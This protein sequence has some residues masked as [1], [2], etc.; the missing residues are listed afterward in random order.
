MLSLPIVFVSHASAAAVIVDAFVDTILR[1]GCGLEP[2]QIFYSSGED[3]GVP[4][5]KD[6]IHHVREQ[7]GEPILVVAIISPTYQTRPVCVAEL[8]AAWG[9]SGDLFPLAVPGMARTDMEGVLEGMTVRYLNDGAALDELR[10]RINKLTGNTSSTATW[11]RYKEQWR[12]DVDELAAKVASPRAVTPEELE[13]AQRDLTGVR[14]ALDQAETENKDLRSRI[15]RYQ[16]ATLQKGAQRR[17]CLRVR[18]TGLTY[19]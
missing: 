10:D 2:D 16:E 11:G 3:T 8:G 12:R 9:R 1:L 5:G 17:S 4:A 14:E 7:A 18:R 13:R 19:L 6:M 15:E